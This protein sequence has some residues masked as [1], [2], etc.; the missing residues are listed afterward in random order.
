MSETFCVSETKKQI[1]KLKP[2]TLP[3]IRANLRNKFLIFFAAEM[4]IRI[5]VS[6]ERRKVQPFASHATLHGPIKFRKLNLQTFTV[7]MRTAET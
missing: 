7:K 6:S 3:S 1:E 2:E 4:R 5:S